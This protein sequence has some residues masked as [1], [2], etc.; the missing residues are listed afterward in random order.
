MRTGEGTFFYKGT[1]RGKK[2]Y[3]TWLNNLRHG[4]GVIIFPDGTKY[5]GEWKNDMKHGKGTLTDRTGRYVGAFRDDMPHGK[6][7][8][9]SIVDNSTIEGDWVDGVGPLDRAKDI[10]TL[11]SLSNYFS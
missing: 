6:G 5:D 9:T 11:P 4:V 10:L 7:V 3:G 8:F 1:P 2:Y